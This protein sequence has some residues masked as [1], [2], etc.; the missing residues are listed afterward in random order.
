MEV[1]RLGHM[2]L[3]EEVEFRCLTGNFQLFQLLH[4]RH[5]LT[6]LSLRVFFMPLQKSASFK[7]ALPLNGFFIPVHLLSSEDFRIAC[8]QENIPMDKTLSTAGD[9]VN[10]RYGKSQP[11]NGIYYLFP[12]PTL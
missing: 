1:A 12:P 8:I 10:N 11:W 2:P 5:V 3:N 7:S 6:G 9:D 4:L